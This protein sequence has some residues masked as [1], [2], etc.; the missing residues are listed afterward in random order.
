M[1]IETWR[2]GR[3]FGREIEEGE[4]E[5]TEDDVHEVQAT[6]CDDSQVPHLDS[7]VEHLSCAATPTL[8]GKCSAIISQCFWDS[9]MIP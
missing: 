8:A 4:P 2:G 3:I 9:K 6:T 1:T 5:G 7:P